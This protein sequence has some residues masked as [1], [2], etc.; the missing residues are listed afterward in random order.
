MPPLESEGSRVEQIAA[1][2]DDRFRL[3]TGGSRTALRRQQTL[4][5]TIDWS[6]DLLSEPERVLF[7]RLAVFVGRLDARGGRGGLREA[8]EVDDRADEVLDLLLRLVDRSLVVAEAEGQSERYRL[9]ETIRQYAQEKLLE[10]GE[11]APVRDRHRDWCLA[12]AERGAGDDGM[13]SEMR[14][15]WLDRLEVS[16]TTSGRRSTGAWRATTSRLA[17]R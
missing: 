14:C 13:A 1:R 7:R 8:S 9:L 5:A 6:Y 3:L 11:A 16:T 12:L 17:W 10:S 2:L 15:C 4:R